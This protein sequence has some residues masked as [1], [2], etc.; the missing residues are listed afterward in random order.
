[1]SRDVFDISDEWRIAQ[2]KILE[3]VI[4]QSL[5]GIS[6]T[7]EDL[8]DSWEAKI[9]TRVKLEFPIL[10]KQNLRVHFIDEWDK[11][12]ATVKQNE[13][14]A[15]K[16]KRI[17]M[18]SQLIVDLLDEVKTWMKTYSET[19]PAQGGAFYQPFRKSVKQDG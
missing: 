2:I 14:E 8:V 13:T 10:N 4:M 3:S 6:G 19:E 7:D 18:K 16:R 15:S 11:L 5:D 17:L 12:L 1:M 9:P